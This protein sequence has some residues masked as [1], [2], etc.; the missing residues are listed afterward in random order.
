MERG[1]RANCGA[2]FT[3]I[4]L[5]RFSP[6]AHADGHTGPDRHTN[7][8]ADVHT[9]RHADASRHAGADA[10]RDSGTHARRDSGPTPVATPEPTPAWNPSVVPVPGSPYYT[11]W[12]VPFDTAV[13]LSLL[14]RVYCTAWLVDDTEAER[15]TL[16]AGARI[17][18]LAWN[19]ALGLVAFEYAGD[20]PDNNI[21]TA[22]TRNELYRLAIEPVGA[23]TTAWYTGPWPYLADPSSLWRAVDIKIGHRV[24][25]S[26]KCTAQI[27]THE[28]G[29][30][31]GLFHGQQPNAIMVLGLTWPACDNKQIQPWEVLQL[32]DAWGVAPQGSQAVGD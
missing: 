3:D 20:C 5:G 22:N 21:S 7:A 15:E 1:D 23:G 4:R 6:D 32:L 16:R 10:R 28:M 19:E 17:A 2:R 25:Q 27:I 30:A 9:N 13:P 12:R 11:P 14:P 8:D 18:A 31:L 26:T 29:H 24:L